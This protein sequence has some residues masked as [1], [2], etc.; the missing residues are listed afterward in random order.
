MKIVSEQVSGYMYFV[1]HPIGAFTE[2]VNSDCVKSFLKKKYLGKKCHFL[3]VLLLK[4]ITADTPRY[5][6]CLFV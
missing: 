3:A 5:P 2:S 6:Y 4:N 1:P